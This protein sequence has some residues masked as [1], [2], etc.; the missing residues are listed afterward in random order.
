[1]ILVAM[2]L[3]VAVSQVDA[4]ADSIYSNVCLYPKT[5]D[6]GGMELRIVRTSRSPS[7]K[8]RTCQ[9]GCWEQPTSAVTL[10]KERITFLAA[11]QSFDEKGKLAESVVHRFSGT[12][13][14]GDL[15]VAS[16]GYYPI[17]HLKKQRHSVEAQAAT[18]K[19]D[20]AAWPAPVRRCR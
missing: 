15:V 12:F 3:A 16:P 17:Q 2:A 14:K 5:L 13:Q 9:G 8:F 11:D 20:P 18:D 10:S 6:Q 4:G 7:V 19:G 1:M